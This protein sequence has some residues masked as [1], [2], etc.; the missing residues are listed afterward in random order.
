MPAASQQHLGKMIVGDLEKVRTCI[1]L[2][3]CSTTQQS[4]YNL[5]LLL[6][7]AT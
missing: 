3:N 4:Q 6:A 2:K 7:V 1:T 5:S